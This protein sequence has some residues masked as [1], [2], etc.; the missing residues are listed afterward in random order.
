MLSY[1]IA[2]YEQIKSNT[3]L[4][5]FNICD[6]NGNSAYVETEIPSSQVSSKSAQEIC[7]IAHKQIQPKIEKIQQDFEKNNA[8]KIG[9]RFIPSV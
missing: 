8:V 2:R 9:Y 4:I 1:T 6:E 3:F 5:A 7:E